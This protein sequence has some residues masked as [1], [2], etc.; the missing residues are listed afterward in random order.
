[1]GRIDVLHGGAWGTVC[2]D[3]WDLW[4]AHV[5]CRQLGCG[6]ALSALRDA[7]LGPGLGAS[8]W[9]SW[10][11]WATSLHCGSALRVAGAN[12]TAATR[13]T[14]GS[15]AQEGSVCVAHGAAGH[16]G[17]VDIR[18]CAPAVHILH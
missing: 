6:H 11:A 15:S 4:H 16:Q 1:V 17:S 18:L 13:R 14:L 2:E 12:M 10:A 5:V 7:H 3:T 8:G 9:T